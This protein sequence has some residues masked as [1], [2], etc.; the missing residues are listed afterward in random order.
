MEE[1]LNIILQKLD[2][3]EVEVKSMGKDIKSLETDV[4]F[5]KDGQERIERKIGG[6]PEQYEQLEVYLAKQHLIVGTL[7]A[8][9]IEHESEIKDLRRLVNN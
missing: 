4:K 2:N 9:S 6:I 1:V 5:L 3:I 8:R 7:S